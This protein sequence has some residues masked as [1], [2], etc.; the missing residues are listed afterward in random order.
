MMETSRNF[1]RHPDH[2]IRGACFVIASSL[3]FAM[4]GGLIKAVSGHLPLVVIVFF[5]N[6]F[7][8]LLLSLWLWH[9]G[10]VGL[11]THRLHLHGIR[12][13]TGLAAMYCFFFTLGHL[14]LG[15]AILLNFTTPLFVPIIALFWL[16]ETL[17]KK[18]WW[19]V[20]LGFAGIILIL[21]PTESVFAPVA[22]IGLASGMFAAVAMVGIRSLS[23]TEPP[24]RIVF[25]FGAMAT[26]ISSLPLL[27]HWQT[28]APAEWGALLA[29]G[30]LAHLGQLFL[31]RG[32]ALGPGGQISPFSYSSV[33]FGSAIG[34]IVWG[35]RLDGFSLVGA[36]TVG[37]AGILILRMGK[38][39]T[40]Q[41][42]QT[43]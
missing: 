17:P 18:M 40:P 24:E 5:R 41:E 16:G 36:L 11:H 22:L 37:L 10:K 42:S 29:I 25:Y 26:L 27:W 8:L 35:E 15:E 28:P 23:H 20:G 31:T 43:S 32:Y 19:A 38:S 4:M 13:L 30:I 21:H 3:M 9:T 34:G 14:H 6:F 12:T 39:H 2:L 7:G 33:V 1:H